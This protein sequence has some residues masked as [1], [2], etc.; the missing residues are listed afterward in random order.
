MMRTADLIL[1]AAIFAVTLFLAVRC[2]RKDGKWDRGYGR[3]QFCFFTLQSNVLCA[4]SA[5][6]MCFFRDSRPVWLLKYIGTAAVTVT[7]LTVFFF[8]APSIGKGGLR[9]LLKGGA[10]FLHFLTPVMALV[11]F[12]VFER[13][14][15][16]FAQAL[17]GMLPLVYYGPLY[18]YK[19]RWA[20]EGKA[21]KDFYGFNRSGKWPVSLA[22]M[23]LGTF[24]ICMAL[25][26]VQNA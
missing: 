15:M 20:P 12:C 17:L 6:L 25:M 3:Y 23:L 21:W 9:E 2:F 7:M 5:L 11:S 18:L 10:F 16:S 22:A 8:L 19:I 14:G 26:A 24:L 4:V 13:R 1:N